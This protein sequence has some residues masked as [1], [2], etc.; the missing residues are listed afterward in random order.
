MIND[1]RT[2]GGLIVFGAFAL[3]LPLAARQYW[4]TGTSFGQD[5]I[6]NITYRSQRLRR[7]HLRAGIPT[8]AV[9]YMFVMLTLTL[10]ILHEMTVNPRVG[11]TVLAGVAW[12]G[13]LV[14]ALST[15]I[16][17]SIVLTNRPRLFVPPRFKD[18]VG[19]L[20]ERRLAN[21]E[22][23]QT[24]LVSFDVTPMHGL[25][26][27]GD[28][29]APEV[30]EW[31]DSS[32]EPHVVSNGRVIL[33]ATRSHRE[34]AVHVAVQRGS[35]TQKQG[36]E[37]FSGLLELE[38]GVLEVGNSLAFDLRTVDLS[39]STNAAVTILVDQLDGA[40]SVTILLEP[41]HDGA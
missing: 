3:L 30:P 37:I 21:P 19:L 13:L 22:E 41:A 34:G 9:L 5:V 18:D 16:Y 36:H 29:D 40:R 11:R 33:I 35:E 31:P 10:L 7:G 2:I 38:R 23:G 15:F 26:Q 28:R 32:P 6:A 39:P 20:N 14:C 1:Y 12:L 17:W 25:V 4:Q 8:V 24:A 27:V